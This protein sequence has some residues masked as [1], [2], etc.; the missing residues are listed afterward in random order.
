MG[1]KPSRRMRLTA[2]TNCAFCARVIR[3]SVRRGEVGEN[4]LQ[5]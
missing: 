2:F 3:V 5:L 4:A 1:L